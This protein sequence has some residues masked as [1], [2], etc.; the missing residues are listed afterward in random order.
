M[1]FVLFQV[2]KALEH[3]KQYHGSAD[4]DVTFIA[5]VG[6]CGMVRRHFSLLDFRIGFGA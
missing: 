1:A 3:L 4:K 6:R 2:D 5:T